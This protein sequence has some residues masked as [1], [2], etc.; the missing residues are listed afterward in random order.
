MGKISNCIVRCVRVVINIQSLSSEINRQL[1]LYSNV[2]E[3]KVD[4]IAEEVASDAVS[5]LKSRSPK[6][7]GDYAKK[8]TYK[9]VGKA[10]VIYNKKYQLTHLLEKGHVK[11]GG[12]R[13]AARVHIKPVE[14]E[15]VRDFIK[16]IERAARR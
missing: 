4:E 13:V 8:W 5:K 10:Y 6:D 9:K 3:D 15:V 7:T 16:K 14:E 2:L 12:G 11:A 1:Q